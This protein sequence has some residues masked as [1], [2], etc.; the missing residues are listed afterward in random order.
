M[1]NGLTAKL[2]QKPW[3]ILT[4]VAFLLA[5]ALGIRMLELTNPPN[6][7]YMVRQ[8]RSLLIARGMYYAQLPNV[9]QW[10]R[11]FAITQWKEEG[12]IEPPIMERLVAL[13]YH[14]IGE[15]L[16]VG[17]VYA[18][19]F[20]LL[21]GLAVWLLAKEL[22]MKEGGIIALAYFLYLPFGVTAS[23]AFM[24][25]SL[26]TALIAWS[27]WSLY[28]WEKKHTWRSAILTG[29]ITGIAILVKSVAVFPLLGAAAA[30]AISRRSVRRILSDRQNWAVAGIT[31]LPTVLFYIYGLFIVRVLQGQF[32]LRFFPALLQDPSFYGRWLFI[33]AGIVGFAPM[34]ISLAGILL[35]PRS[36]ARFM[37]TGAWIGYLIYGFIFPYH[38]I[39]HE[40]YHLPLIPIIAIG[41]IP[42]ADLLIRQI[43]LQRGILVRALFIGLLLFGV[44]MKMWEARNTLVRDDYRNE[45]VFWQDLGK[46][47]GHDKNIIELSGDYGY[48]LAYF[49]WVRGSIWST[50]A[51]D[52]LRTLAGQDQTNFATTFAEKTSGKDL[53][54]VTSPTEWENQPELR[55]YLTANYPLVAENQ[56]DGYWIFNLKP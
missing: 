53:F 45:I 39:T 6:D 51:D 28:R 43:A 41:M 27:L 20:W 18:L 46:E 26:M 31:A 30:L 17:R 35:F 36:E 16:W 37:I 2:F 47:I 48:R 19:L 21:G 12:L 25:D 49:G 50:T 13:T 40:Y 5:G 8:Y 11:D 3:P 22:S 32:S 14:I 15:H 4:L 9:S 38:F 33:A 34:F 1:I 54:V 10:Q 52:A 55:D 23:R 42:V 56:S 44:A 24:P 29:L 7:F